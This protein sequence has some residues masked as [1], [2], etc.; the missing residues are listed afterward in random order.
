MLYLTYEKYKEIGGEQSETAFNKN[1]NRACGVID[2][3]TAGRIEKTKEIP[4]QVYDLCRELVDYFAGNFGS[5]KQ[6]SSASQSSGGVSQSESYVIR[7]IE[8][9]A[10][11]LNDLV[12]DYLLNVKDDEGTPVL[13]RGCSR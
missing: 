12:K 8:E 13:Y 5:S 7:S 11:E 10:G 1:I 3:F 2:N 6:I 4:L 9:R